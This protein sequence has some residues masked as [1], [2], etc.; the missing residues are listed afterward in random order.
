LGL[1]NGLGFNLT[2]PNLGLPYLVLGDL[3][4]ENGGALNIEPGV[5][6]R[7]GQNRGVTVKTGGQLIASGSANA[8]ITFTAAALYPEAGSWRGVELLAG[9]PSYLKGCLVSY[10]GGGDDDE[11]GAVHLETEATLQGCRIEHSLTHAIT[12]DGVQPVIKANRFAANAGFDLFNIP[13]SQRE[14]VDATVNWWGQASG[15]KATG[16]APGNSVSEAVLVNPWLASPDPRNPVQAAEVI[17]AAFNPQGGQAIL[18]A[19]FRTSIDWTLTILD[20]SD[21][22]VYSAVGSGTQLRAVWNGQTNGDPLP[23]GV[24][25]FQLTTF[26]EGETVRILAGQF[27]L[28]TT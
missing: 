20:P 28:N 16:D 17:S 21:A 22:E 14:I 12:I 26:L 19:R 10:A 2:L 25:R 4:I 18:E 15:P 5:E 27:V 8:P 6:L 24:Y 3:N 13:G 7:F 9:Q 23:A 11:R 1:E